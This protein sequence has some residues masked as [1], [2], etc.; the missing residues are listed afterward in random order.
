MQLQSIGIVH[1]PIKERELRDYKATTSTIVI[2]E[3]FVEA[4]DGIEAFSHITVLFWF[5]LS[6][7][8]T[9]LK[10]HPRGDPRN[11]LRGI[12]AT[13]S[14]VRP[15]PIGMTIVRLLERQGNELRIQGLDAIDGTPVVDIKPYTRPNC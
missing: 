4:L 9:S 7:K 8:P 3:E 12:F 6:G 1:S 11:P 15:N 10:V 14:P 13:C 5:H 2:K